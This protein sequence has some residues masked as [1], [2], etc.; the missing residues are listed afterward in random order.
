MRSTQQLS[1]TVPN[2]MAQLIRAKVA[3][4]EYASESEVIRDG[5]RALMGA[6][7]GSGELLR[8]EA[9]PAYDALQADPSRGRSVDDVRAA[10][11]AETQG[12]HR[13]IMTYTVIF[14]PEAQDQLVSLYR[15][16]A[17]KASAEIATRLHRCHREA[18]RSAHTISASRHGARRHSA[19][20]A[21]HELPQTRGDRLRRAGR[22]G[23]DYRCIL[24]WPGL[25][26]RAARGS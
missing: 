7:P 26:R 21:H 2:E 9:A 22:S 16:I 4:G 8:A 23:G 6:R 20:A 13:K 19:G 24:W 25:C 1:I 11:A 18:L 3:S 12:S 5:L 17:K 10:L 15:Y 14:T